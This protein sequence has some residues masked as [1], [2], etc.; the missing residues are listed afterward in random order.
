MSTVKVGQVWRDKDK[1][2]NTVIEIVSV[3][4]DLRG[5]AEVI[6]L[7]VGTEDE[8]SYRIERLL[9]RW[10]MLEDKLSTLDEELEQLIKGKEL[11]K[12]HDTRE[13]WLNAAVD[14]LKDGIF[15]PKKFDVPEVRV[16]VGWPG[17]RGPKANIIGQCWPGESATDKVGQI[18]ISPVLVEPVAVLETL[19]HEVVHAINH[20]NG[21]TG[22]RGPFRRIAEVLGLEGKMTA[23]HAGEELA[24]KLE[25]IGNQLGEYP[26]AGI[27]PTER[28]KVQKTY[29]LKL[30]SPE[31]P[32]YFV[33][34]TQGKLDEYG[35]PRDPWGNEMELER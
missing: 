6:G 7:V 9:K 20:A 21:E 24:E 16:S 1:R 19:V 30:V 8:R 22:H 33:R 12:I 13:A 2:R 35:A 34:M 29:M 10:E 18:F 25:E 23:T 17:G 27:I 14:K 26:H 5:D 28:P 3:P 15:E 32:D 31:E 4:N 11:P